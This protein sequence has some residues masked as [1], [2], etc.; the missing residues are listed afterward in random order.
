MVY[1]CGAGLSVPSGIRAYRTGP[2]ALWDSYVTSW[3]TRARFVAEPLAWWK[4]FWLT[5]HAQILGDDVRP[6]AGHLALA[7]LARRGP[8]DI[9]I[10]QNIDGLHRA[11]GHPEAQLIEIHGRHD[12]FVC[13]TGDDCARYRTPVA[14]VDLSRLGAG[15][16]PHCDGCGALMRPLVLLFDEMYDGHPDYQA[17]R[18]RRALDDA[19]AIVFVGTSFSVG[20]TGSALRSADVSGATLININP[21]PPARLGRPL[22]HLS[23]GAE[24]LLPRLVDLLFAP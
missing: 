24:V 8:E 14:S 17:H 16:M 2:D 3:G 18:A 4:E 23:G 6:N 5:A 19:D 1:L 21:E 20:I 12:R 9:V 10:T 11:A 13:L 7:A 15:C 22:A